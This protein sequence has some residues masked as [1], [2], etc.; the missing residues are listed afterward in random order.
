MNLMGYRI[1]LKMFIQGIKDLCYLKLFLFIFFEVNMFNCQIMICFFLNK[2]VILL[3]YWF[4]WGNWSLCF[5]ECKRKKYSIC[6]RMCF[7]N[8]DIYKVCKGYSLEVRKCF[9][10][11]KLK[12]L[13]FIG[14]IVVKGGQC[15]SINYYVL[16]MFDS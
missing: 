1:Y 15:V 3:V 4:L 5:K 9:C 11:L 2:I 6:S 7:V 16:F 10:V 14:F 8:E 13:K 12:F